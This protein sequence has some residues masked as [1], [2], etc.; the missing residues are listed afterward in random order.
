MDYIPSRYNCF[1]DVDEKCYGYNFL[2]RS[3]IRIA[4]SGYD[5]I[6]QALSDP[7]GQ[8]LSTLP[9]DA[10][11]G[12][13]AADFLIPSDRDE[14]AVIK[15]RYNR[16]LFALNAV[17]L[18]ILPTLSCNLSCPYCFVRQTPGIMTKEVA[19]AIDQWIRRAFTPK[20][21]FYVS[22]Y[23]GEPLLAK[24]LIG[25]LSGL[26]LDV[27]RQWR[28]GYV[29]SMTTN[30]YYLDREVIDNIENWGL[31]SIQI[32]LDGDREYHDELRK[33]RGGG[34]SFDRI[35]ENIERFCEAS[36][37]CELT[38]RI[39]C[40]DDNYES[41]FN[42]L[43]RFGE[44]VRRKAKVYFCWVW[45]NKVSGELNLAAKGLAS[46]SYKRIEALYRV[47]NLS[48]WVTTNPA[49][50][51]TDGYCEVDTPNHFHIDPFGNLYLCSYTFDPSEA[52]GSV[53]Q[54]GTGLN[55]NMLDYYESWKAVNP[56]ND[57]ECVSCILL[58]ACWGGCRKE[59]VQGR[60]GACLGERDEVELF[61]ESIVRD[62]IL[63]C[64]RYD[65]APETIEAH[66][67]GNVIVIRQRYERM[68]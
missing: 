48:G 6:R 13:A 2:Y 32:S 5:Q 21:H 24:P 29:A 1:F 67:P 68:L 64:S 61:A 47:A 53:F 55:D 12:L 7:S 16:Q 34:G 36:P 51:S 4:P 41:V 56:F 30:G 14:L 60:R 33:R 42:L 3:I 62:Y 18:I 44:N 54:E 46:D 25:Q 58:P 50:R 52:V 43:K 23:G 35:V 15:V 49:T 26:L 20:R 22:W 40:T 28:A 39:N 63:E 8:L 57:S 10:E 65:D 37:R 66:D 27:C 45:P 38:L 17:D 31:R 9:P 59:R 11:T 19:E